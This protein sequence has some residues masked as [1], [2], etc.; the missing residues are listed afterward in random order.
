[1]TN[2]ATDPEVAAMGLINFTWTD[3][4]S[5]EIRLPVDPVRIARNLGVQVFDAPLSEDISGSLVKT[6]G[7]DPVILLN[8]ADSNS[9]RRFTCA[10]ELGHFV[11]RSGDEQFEYI[12]HRGP[13]A[14]EG[15]EPSEIYA[16]QF[17][18]AMLMPADLVRK[19]ASGK[20]TLELARMFGVSPDAMKF[21]LKN[22]QL[23]A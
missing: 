5:G 17:A 1:M 9:R 12:E 23:A 3:P 20:G 7:A 8:R 16:N 11:R 19:H 15:S 21:R 6:A 18:A 14:T 22:L 2:K 13:I 4:G 10:H